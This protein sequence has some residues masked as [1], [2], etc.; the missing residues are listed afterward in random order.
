MKKIILILASVL[1]AAGCATKNYGR[2]GEITKFEEET[3]SCREIAI[4]SA[5]VQGFI[6]HVNK[7]SEFDGR[8]VLAILGDFGIGNAMERDAAM[9]SANTR[10]DRLHALR[11]TK[12]CSDHAAI[13]S[14]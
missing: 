7:E 5:K 8:D 10:L 1:L 2:Q 4:E 11:R 13:S 3:L 9:K 6:N 14:H 12:N